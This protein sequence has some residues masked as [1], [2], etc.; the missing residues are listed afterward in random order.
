MPGLGH[1]RRIAETW[2]PAATGPD[3]GRQITRAAISFAVAW[4]VGPSRPVSSLIVAGDH[5]IDTLTAAT[6][7]PERGP[8]DQH[9]RLR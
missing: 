2:L 8:D 9:G 3:G 5:G 4:T 6:T 1:I 7:S